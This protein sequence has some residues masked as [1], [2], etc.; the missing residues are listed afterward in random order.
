[1]STE[2]CIIH[3]DMDAFYASVEQR[4][5]P[6][7][8]G[9]PVL[10]GGTGAR[11]VVAAASYEARQFGTHSAMPM[12][13]AL[14]LC[15]EAACVRPRMSHYKSVSRQIF[16]V[17]AEF[18]PEVEGLSLDEA[19]LDVSGSL[20]LFGPPEK[21]GRAIKERVREE[22]QLTA[23]VGIGP[24]KLVAK[25]A[26]DLEK[27]DGLCV[28][29]G[30][31]IRERLDPL[32]VKVIGGIGPRTA[33][34]LA[35]QGILT[36]QELR[37]AQEGLLR[38]A[39]GRDAHRMQ[40]RAA[41]RDDRPVSSARAEISISAEETFDTDL[42]DRAAMDGIIREQAEEVARRCRKG[43]WQAGVVVLK[44]RRA[45]FS[46]YTRQRRVTPPLSE[47]GPVFRV[48]SE[49]LERWLL[50]HPGARVRLLGVGV[51]ALS[52]DNQLGLFETGPGHSPL[53]AAVADIRDRYGDGAVQTD[54][55][56][57]DSDGIQG[58]RS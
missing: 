26:S 35:G 14:R 8:Q 20:A 10:V 19:F 28:L 1:M 48:A 36:V 37:T 25:I 57:P 46:T 44:V 41:G 11:G 40:A 56:I 51:S 53:K 3:V 9:R 13:R 18:T 7:L 17:F 29:F 2:R 38:R 52:E 16:D 55:R 33:E 6:E 42:D 32:S 24:N 23:S 12:G 54:S 50:E 47:A 4:D 45:D 21:L 31:T 58:R 15:P 49:L 5:N 34:R 43:S 30:A 39:L 22:T 27:P